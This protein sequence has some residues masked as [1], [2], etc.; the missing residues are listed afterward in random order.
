MINQLIHKV[1]RADTP[2]YANLKKT[3]KAILRF[4]I[5][6]VKA[7][8]LPLYHLHIFLRKLF[9]TMYMGLWAAP[10][11]K[12]RCESCGSGLNIPGG[13]PVVIGTPKLIIGNNVTMMDASISSGHVFDNPELIIGDNTVIG[14]HSDISVANRVTIGNNCLISKDC[15]I[16]DNNGHPVDPKR[17]HEPLKTSEVEFVHISNNV[18]IGVGCIILKGTSIGA[19]SVIAANSVVA[20]KVPPNTVYSGTPVSYKTRAV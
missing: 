10:L 14:Y 2:F 3:L 18:W 5:P 9:N 11:F 13:V 6:S 12:A 4:N 15:F 17:R 7:I 20:G 8:H 16:A 1:R 19:N